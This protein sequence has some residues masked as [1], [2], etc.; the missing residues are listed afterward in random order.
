[1]CVGWV[2]VDVEALSLAPSLGS[3]VHVFGCHHAHAPCALASLAARAAG[4]C[5]PAE[6]HHAVQHP[7]PLPG[8]C[9]RRV[10]VMVGRGWGC[11]VWAPVAG[12][13]GS[14]NLLRRAHEAPTQH[15]LASLS[16]S[17]PVRLLV[18]APLVHHMCDGGGRYGVLGDLTETLRREVLLHINRDVVH[19]VSLFTRAGQ[20]L[21]VHLLTVITPAFALADEVILQVR[22]GVGQ[23]LQ[24]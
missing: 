6:A 23:S 18:C 9:L 2:G 11:A 1:M 19:G 15:Q 14:G 10:R 3:Y 21:V 13:D 17:I 22:A 5:T 16:L 7:V 4:T 20:P 8:L 12:H 24:G